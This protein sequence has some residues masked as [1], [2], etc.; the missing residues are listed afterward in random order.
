DNISDALLLKTEAH[1]TVKWTS[2]MHSYPS[3][4][5]LTSAFYIFQHFFSSAWS[6]TSTVFEY[7]M[8]LQ[9]LEAHLAGIKFILSN[10]RLLAFVLINSLPKILEW[11]MFTS[12]DINTIEDSRLTSDTVET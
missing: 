9:T 3:T 6:G 10:S 12:S 8:S 4:K 7:I 11:N 2:S 1:T 5:N